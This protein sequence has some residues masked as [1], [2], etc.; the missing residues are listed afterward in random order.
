MFFCQP[1]DSI[2]A[3]PHQISPGDQIFANISYDPLSL[4]IL[5]DLLPSASGETIK[6]ELDTKDDEYA[7]M[8]KATIA[9]AMTITFAGFIPSGTS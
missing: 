7:L 8:S 5:V 1:A 4:S 2:K 3:V 6:F 9:G